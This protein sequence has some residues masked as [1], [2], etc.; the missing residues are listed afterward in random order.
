MVDMSIGTDDVEHT[1]KIEQTP[2]K[3][4]LDRKKDKNAPVNVVHR[5]GTLKTL[6]TRHLKELE[7][8]EKLRNTTL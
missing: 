3:P 6:Q 8:V 5:R 2:K 4:N 1:F 7:I